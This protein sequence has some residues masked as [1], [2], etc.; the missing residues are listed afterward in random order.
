M[1]LFGKKFRCETCGMKFRTEAELREHG[2]M[3]MQQMPARRDFTCQTCGA[4]FHSETELK[5]HG[6]RV[7]G[8]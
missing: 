2:K 7:H 6:A 3:H 4:S 1:A 5:Q 8:M